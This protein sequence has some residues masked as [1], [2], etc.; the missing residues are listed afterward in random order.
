MLEKRTRT[1]L[2]ILINL[3]G[4]KIFS[5]LP[6]F[7]SNY[8][9]TYGFTKLI[10]RSR[11]VKFTAR[12]Y[13]G[14]Y[15]VNVQGDYAVERMAAQRKPEPYDPYIG[16]S[17][18]NLDG[19]NAIDIGANVGTISLALVSLG[20]KRVYSI[21]P[22]PLHERLNGNIQLNKLESVVLPYKIGFGAEVGELFWAEDKNNPGN[23]HLV[24]SAN[25]INFKKITTKFKESDFIRVPV[26][27]LDEF[28]STEV[29]GSVDI[30]KI[31]VEG[32]EWSVLGAGQNTIRL[33]LP[34]VVAETHRVASDMMKY[35]C[36][37]PMFQ[38]FYSLGYRTF[39]LDEN[40][41]LVEFIYPNFGFDT[42]F[43]HEKDL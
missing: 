7:V 34:I 37:T 10:K 11:N 2:R 21:E 19:K 33:H 32:M 4:R 14:E 35:D 16:L 39:S 17:K 30:I 8:L 28:V 24:G 1:Y 43:I 31:D 12:L 6:G 15:K 29:G 27:T 38:F 18:L 22:G 42:F 9:G 13:G 5:L 26:T 36:V 25:E 41:E 23:A 20:C 40:N 3:I